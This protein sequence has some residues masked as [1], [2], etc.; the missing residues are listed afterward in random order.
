VRFTHHKE[1]IPMITKLGTYVLIDGDVTLTS[2][3]PFPARP[4]EDHRLDYLTPPRQPRGIEL[5][6]DQTIT[7]S[8]AEAIFVVIGH[9]AVGAMIGM[10][11]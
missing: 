3:H 1:T 4:A 6:L 9:L 2:D 5:W 10:V 7:T 8:L 11:L